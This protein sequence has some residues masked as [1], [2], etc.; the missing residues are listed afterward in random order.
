MSANYCLKAPLG[1][2]SL[3]ALL[4]A[5]LI[6]SPARAQNQPLFPVTPLFD[7]G[8]QQVLA[9]GDFNGDGQPDLITI[10]P[11]NQNSTLITLLNQGN[12]NPP[13]AVTAALNFAPFSLIAVDINNDKKLD[14]VGNV[15]SGTAVLIGNGDGTF[16]PP[17]VY[18]IVGPGNITAVDLNGD[19]YLDL[20]FI[21]A[22]TL[23]SFQVEVLLNQGSSAPGIFSPSASY[24]LSITYA[25]LNSTVTIGSGDFNGDGKQDI[26]VGGTNTAVFY[27]NGDGT[28]QTQQSPP[29]PASL[30]GGAYFVAADLNQDGVSD[31]AYLAFAAPNSTLLSLQVM[32]G[33]SNGIF[34]VGS[35]LPLGFTGPYQLGLVTAGTTGGNVNLAFINQT[36]TIL[37]GDGNGNFSQGS[38]YP[39]SGTLF[40]IPGKN[41]NTDFA[42]ELSNQ[43]ID[44][45]Q[46]QNQITR[47]V[48]NGDGTF[49]GIPTLPVGSSSFAASDFN[50]D[51]LT[52]VLTLDAR[53]NLV[54]AI[55]RGNGT[56]TVTSH[57]TGAAAKVIVTADFNA[58][59]DQ[60][61]AIITPGDGSL[62]PAKPVVDSTLIFYKGNGDGTF[63]P[64]ASPVDLQVVGAISA[65]S[66][67]FNG[68]GKIDVVAAYSN[69][70]DDPTSSY[71]IVFLPGKGD[72]TFGTPVALPSHNPTS[73][74]SLILAADLN[75]DHKLDI[76]W[77]GLVYLGNGDGTFQLSTVTLPAPALAVGDLNGDGIPDAVTGGFNVGASVYAGNGDG[78]FQNSPF[79]TATL[80][81]FAQMGVAT[82]TDV[83]AD[84]HPD[85]LLQYNV[86]ID[87]QL[88]RTS[89]TPFLGDGKGNFTA[90]SNT[91]YAGNPSGIIGE[92]DGGTETPSNV[93]LARLNNQVS[94]QSKTAAL[95][96]LTWT[97]GGATAL[98]NQTNPAPT[99]PSLFPSKTALAVSANNA[100]PTQQL[101]FT[102]TVTGVISPSGSVSFTS[103]STPLGTASITN[104]VA[105]LSISFP[106][107]G[108]YAVTASY[109]GDTNNQPSSSSP[110]SVTVAPVASKTTLTASANSANPNQQLTFTAAVTGSNPTGNVTF[111]S[112][113]TTLGTASLTNGTASL[114]FA[115]TVAGSFTVTANYAGDAANL[116]SASSALTV[117]V[118]APD[119]TLS[120]SPAAATIAAGQSA[121]TTFSVA[122]LGGYSGTVTFSC[123]TLP[124]GAA[125]TFAPAS[126]TPASGATATTTLTITTTA[127][128]TALLPRLTLPLHGIAFASLVLLVFSPHRLRKFSRRLMRAS[129]L[130]VLLAA[131]LLSLVGCSSSPKN[132]TTTNPGTPAGLQTIT[133]TAAD[134][135]GKLSHTATF[136]VTVQ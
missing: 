134:S 20:A 65:V 34:T 7:I 36:T 112:G 33:H 67:D 48:S 116:A 60:D 47:L 6:S 118:A 41:G 86:L 59:G 87:D 107:T 132:P 66:G 72:G 76:L 97:S 129:L 39:F 92:A 19:G 21:T 114:P 61:A 3:L 120:A 80:P 109:A 98:L 125:C 40:P 13:L 124:L 111:T 70:Y 12:T 91:Y 81:T 85:L 103:G 73:V 75:N 56:F 37:R 42:L 126:V 105:T 38:S 136:Q 64:S 28:L 93:V 82:I 84:S 99:A 63:Q 121:M 69:G 131:G 17:V 58:D 68:D 110:V 71:G 89:L 130:T 106:A 51:G 32:L 16:Q 9:T 62:Y 31:I 119:F 24:P 27:G 23:L 26:F 123:G 43:V 52:D 94:P 10:L 122:P 15:A 95:D 45:D 30:P 128:T 44:A 115:F 108:T 8:D 53:N 54:T 18:P 11:N 1:V 127:P 88:S 35:N 57:T 102:A 74:E 135:A 4:I 101:T 22:K 78:T 49:Q 55:G 104:G 77:N 14:L 113:N 46:I 100:A 117:T 5:I 83:N 50:N 96:Y 29:V 133:V 90:D 25:T 2:R 79:Y